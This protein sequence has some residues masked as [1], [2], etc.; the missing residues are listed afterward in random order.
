MAF[1]LQLFSQKRFILD[2]LQDPKYD[3]A[4]LSLSELAPPPQYRGKIF[5]V[6]LTI[7]LHYT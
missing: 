7:F 3:S 2:V 1:S 6:C 5:K 4:V